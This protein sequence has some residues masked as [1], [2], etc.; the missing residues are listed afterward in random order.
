MALLPSGI[1]LQKTDTVILSSKTSQFPLLLRLHFPSLNISSSSNCEK[2]PNLERGLHLFNTVH[3]QITETLTNELFYLLSA[4]LSKHEIEHFVTDL[5]LN[6]KDDVKLENLRK[7]GRERRSFEYLKQGYW[8]HSS[9]TED[10]FSEMSTW[11]ENQFKNVNKR[12]DQTGIAINET[13]NTLDSVEK[14]ICSLLEINYQNAIES[15]RLSLILSLNNLIKQVNEIKNGMLPASIKDEFINDFCLRHFAPNK[16]SKFCDKNN[17]RSL[18]TVKLKQVIFERNLVVGLKMSVKVPKTDEVEHFIFQVRFVPI[19]SQNMKNVT[20]KGNFEYKR[21]KNSISYIGIKKFESN[22]NY[23]TLTGFSSNNCQINNFITI[24]HERAAQIEE[25]CLENLL[26]NNGVTPDCEIETK[27]GSHDC[28]THETKNGQIVSSINPISIQI[29][30]PNSDLGSIF[31]LKNKVR[32][33]FFYIP[34]NSK[35]SSIFSC[36]KKQ[37]IVEIE[38]TPKT[39]IIDQQS[40]NISLSNEIVKPKLNHLDQLRSDVTKMLQQKPN[41]QTSFEKFW[42]KHVGMTAGQSAKFSGFSF[43]C[44]IIFVIIIYGIRKF[45]ERKQARHVVVNTQPPTVA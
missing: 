29:Y 44:F 22:S 15:L 12:I 25:T 39:I 9:W 45:C 35:F 36:N 27:F 17:I 10:K 41:D 26:L 16:K 42:N 3:K 32:K 20:R 19:V 5:M 37:I 28:I 4:N 30:D 33:G 21:L 23:E 7:I 24:C 31:T 40:F 43:S 34:Q 1:F 14:E 8:F 6:H 2:T 11:A 13:L 18:F 38:E